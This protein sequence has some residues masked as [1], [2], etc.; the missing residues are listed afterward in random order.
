[1]AKRKTSQELIEAAKPLAD[2]LENELIETGEIKIEVRGLTY[3]E[4]TYARSKA[5]KGAAKDDEAAAEV[6]LRGWYL[7]FG[8]KAVGG[9]DLPREVID[10]GVCKLAAIPESALESLYTY[11]DIADALFW[12]IMSK[13][14]NSEDEL[15]SLDFTS[16]FTTP[17]SSA[18]AAASAQTATA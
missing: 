7:R 11:P 16:L 13:T 17:I 2:K 14:H 6:A 18:A 12:G 1:M 5:R 8:V 3:Q 4:L 10:L 15:D 9:T